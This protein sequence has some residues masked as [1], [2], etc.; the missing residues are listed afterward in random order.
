MIR[1]FIRRISPVKM[2][3]PSSFVSENLDEDDT[4]NDLLFWF[5]IRLGQLNRVNSINSSESTQHS[6]QER[7]TAGQLWSTS[8]AVGSSQPSELTRSSQRVD[9]VNSA[10][11]RS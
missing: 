8:V 3:F 5:P 4:D 1:V 2:S 7:S 10:G 6:G 11:Q 9:S